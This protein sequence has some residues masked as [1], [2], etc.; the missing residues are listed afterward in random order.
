MN[1]YIR[2]VLS[3]LYAIPYK[4]YQQFPRDWIVPEQRQI[5]IIVLHQKV[6]L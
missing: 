2:P 5:G 4:S 6:C 3:S 1:D